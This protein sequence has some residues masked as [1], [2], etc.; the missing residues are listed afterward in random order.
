[1]ATRKKQPRRLGR[2]PSAE[3]SDT[4]KRITET[5]RVLFSERGFE[6]TTNKMLAAEAGITTGALYHYFESKQAIYAA[7]YDEVQEVV[8]G[9]FGLVEAEYHTFIS[10]FEAMLE[11]AYQLNREDPSLARLIGA[12][13]IDERRDPELRSMLAEIYAS[14]QGGFF[15]RLVELG[16]KTGEIDSSH[17]SLVLSLLQ[18]ILIGLTDAVSDDPV[19]H[20]IAI[21]GIKALL[22]GKLIREAPSLGN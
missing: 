6:V 14:R 20:R 12:V 5:A 21:D 9:R 18:I 2:P 1:M 17:R 4:R 7:V 3:S 19:Q 15:E 11:T 13:R 16:I 10:R 8:Y 22:E